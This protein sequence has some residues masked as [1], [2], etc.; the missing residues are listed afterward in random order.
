[1]KVEMRKPHD[2]NDCFVKPA[3]RV[4]KQGPTKGMV[5]E[6]AKRLKK[7]GVVKV[8][9]LKSCLKDHS[10]KEIAEKLSSQ[11]GATIGEIR[12]HTFILFKK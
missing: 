2:N 10:C 11:T 7:T 9:V 4:G 5:E 8:K 3:V 1:M 6:V 12:G